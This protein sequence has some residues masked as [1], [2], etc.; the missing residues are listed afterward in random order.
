M[1]LTKLGIICIIP[2][3]QLIMYAAITGVSFWSAF[4]RVF[5]IGFMGM[6]DK[7]YQMTNLLF[8]DALSA[9]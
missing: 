5:I 3:W 1:L 7:C 4:V 8:E 9:L 2:Y 6:L